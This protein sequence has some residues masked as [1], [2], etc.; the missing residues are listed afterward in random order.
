MTIGDFTISREFKEDGII[1][2]RVSFSPDLRMNGVYTVNG[3]RI[4]INMT[5][6][7]N[8]KNGKSFTLDISYEFSYRFKNG[9]L[10]LIDLA[11]EEVT[12]VVYKR[13]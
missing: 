4:S 10:V 6:F 3:D 1:I 11:F 9:N 7:V 13:E 2:E 5:D 12:E 8:E